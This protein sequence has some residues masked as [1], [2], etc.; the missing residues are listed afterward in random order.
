MLSALPPATPGISFRSARLNSVGEEAGG[1]VPSDREIDGKNIMAMLVG[2]EPSP[3][4]EFLYYFRKRLF[5]IR[6]GRWKLHLFERKV[7]SKG[8]P[9]EPVRLRPP[10]L[11]DLSEDLG[12]EHDIAAQNSEV[13][14][15]LAPGG[16]SF[17]PASG[18]C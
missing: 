7:K 18:R 11:Y 2:R 13:V 15:Q 16:R 1:E 5:A 17:M 3:D 12:E 8:K 4:S 6:D 10:K 14:R 9:G